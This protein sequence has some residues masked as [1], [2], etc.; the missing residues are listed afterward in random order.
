MLSQWH[1][2]SFPDHSFPHT[3]H[4][5]ST[6]RSSFGAICHDCAFAFQ[7]HCNHWVPHTAAHPQ[8]PDAS[9]TSSTLSVSGEGRIPTPF[10]PSIKWLHHCTSEGKSV[11][12]LMKRSLFLTDAISCIMRCTKLRP[13]CTTFTACCRSPTRDSKS[14]RLAAFRPSHCWTT[15]LTLCSFSFGSRSSIFWVSTSM[16]RKVMQVDGPSLLS[17]A[18]GTPSWAQVLRMTARFAAHS[19]EPGLPTVTKSSR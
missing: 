9:E 11:L 16:P 5:S 17:E 3:M 1:L 4:D 18:M 2:I 19:I 15:A 7:R 8:L 10:H 12:S 6:G 14:R 13:E